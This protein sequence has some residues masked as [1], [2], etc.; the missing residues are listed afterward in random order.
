MPHVLE[1]KGGEL[2]TPLNVF[3]VME[4][5]EDYMGTDIR[6]YL[7]EYLEDAQNDASEITDDEIADHYKQILMNIKDETENALKL[8]EKPRMDRSAIQ[9][10]LNL[11]VKMIGREY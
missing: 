3:D 10:A 4:A 6:Q 5:V 11:I 2:L 8:T 9:E 1:I 7:E